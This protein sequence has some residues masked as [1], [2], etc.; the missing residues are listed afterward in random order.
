MASRSTPPPPWIHPP[1]PRPI[2]G[3][4]SVPMDLTS[5]NIDRYLAGLNG[6]PRGY[7]GKV[8]RTTDLFG[9]ADGDDSVE[10]TLFL[11]MMTISIF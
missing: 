11:N 5:I 2:G 6:G 8:L 4:G 7:D 1:R 10:M 9:A 3:S